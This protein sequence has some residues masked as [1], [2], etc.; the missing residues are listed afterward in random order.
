MG[1]W[2][3][4]ISLA[5]RGAKTQKTKLLMVFSAI[6]VIV[7]VLAGYWIIINNRQVGRLID[8]CK[9]PILSFAN[10]ICRD[11]LTNY[12]KLAP[13]HLFTREGLGAIIMA[14]SA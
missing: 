8:V 13:F 14:A 9:L 10:N 1:I 2:W 11:L 3:R 4:S 5:R 12:L 7:I 6:L